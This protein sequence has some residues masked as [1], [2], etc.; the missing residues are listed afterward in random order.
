MSSAHVVAK[1]A[2]RDAFLVEA[3]AKQ[4]QRQPVLFRDACDRCVHRRIV[5]PHSG[6]ACHLQLR[7]I[8]DH[9]FEHL[10]CEHRACGQCDVLPLQLRL[11]DPQARLQLIA[12]DDLVVDHGD[13]TIDDAPRGRRVFLDRALW[14]RGGRRRRSSG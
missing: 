6:F 4:R 11:G 13:D 2:E 8:D 5:D 1:A 14:R 10:A 3:L 12:C 9:A 7:P